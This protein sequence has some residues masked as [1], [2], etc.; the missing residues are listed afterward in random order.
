MLYKVERVLEINKILEV[1]CKIEEQNS[2]NHYKD[3]VFITNYDV[4][5][6][7]SFKDGINQ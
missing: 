6:L 5:N 1:E 3:L 4:R 2:F 7:D